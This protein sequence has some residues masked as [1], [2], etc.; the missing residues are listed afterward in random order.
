MDTLERKT[1]PAA[2]ADGSAIKKEE[3]C[4]LHIT[5]TP[6]FCQTLR[7]AAGWAAVI[8]ILGVAGGIEQ[9][10]IQLWPGCFWMAALLALLNWGSKPWQ[11]IE[12]TDREETAQNADS[13]G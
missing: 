8:G 13:Q 3:P 7:G 9:E 1:A 4:C 6:A 10:T 12:M 2:A 5:I 11:R